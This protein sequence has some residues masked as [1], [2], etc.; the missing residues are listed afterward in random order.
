M[1]KMASEIRFIADCMLGKLSRW[2]RICGFDTLYYQ[3]IHDPDLLVRAEKDERVVL[4]RDRLLFKLSRKRNLEAVLVVHDFFED[5]LKQ[6]FRE[7]NIQSPPMA[8]HRCLNCNEVLQRADKTEVESR[9][10][11][12]ILDTEQKFYVCPACRK[13]YWPGTHWLHMNNSLKRLFG[14]EAVKKETGEDKKETGED[15]KET[16][17]DKKETGEDK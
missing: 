15:K 7:L 9:V 4:T 16:G 10:P 3:Q 12:Y 5:Q 2:L 17:E 13:V 11:S 8:L 14:E 1:G 6:V